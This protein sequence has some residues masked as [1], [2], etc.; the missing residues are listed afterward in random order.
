MRVDRWQTILS[1]LM[2]LTRRG[3]F[4]FECK[5][6]VALGRIFVYFAKKL[7]TSVVDEC[8]RRVS[9]WQ[10]FV[11]PYQTS[12]KPRQKIGE[13]LGLSDFLSGDFIALSCL[14]SVT[15]SIST[16]QRAYRYGI[17]LIQ[18][19]A[20]PKRTSMQQA[21]AEKISLPFRTKISI[22]SGFKEQLALG[23]TCNY[24]QMNREQRGSSFNYYG[25]QFFHARSQTKNKAQGLFHPNLLLLLPMPLQLLHRIRSS[26][27][28]WL[29]KR[30]STARRWNGYFNRANNLIDVL[31]I[32]DKIVNSQC[33]RV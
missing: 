20:K 5:G 17:M 24:W 26:T 15:K 32:K 7:S 10:N 16:F 11:R 8:D 29:K 22:F 21:W 31:G 3:Q 25:S 4:L 30:R 13:P 18:K 23:R 9:S 6:P 33:D 19:R 2:P 1:L 28:H 27:K 12:K 14:F